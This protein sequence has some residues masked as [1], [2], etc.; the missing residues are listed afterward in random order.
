[1]NTLKEE[2]A[3]YLYWT[4]NDGVV[5]NSYRE[6]AEEILAKIEKRIDSK[7]K[8]KEHNDYEEGYNI[9]LEEVKE[10]LK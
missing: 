5:Y 8:P 3:N 10:M 6:E 4:F 1:M 9:A 7:K 2:I